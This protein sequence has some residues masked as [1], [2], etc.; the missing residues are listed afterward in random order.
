[1]IGSL[2]RCPLIVFLLAHWLEFVAATSLLVGLYGLRRMRTAEWAARVAKRKLLHVMAAD[3][4]NELARTS[5]LLTSAVRSGDWRRSGEFAAG[6]TVSLAEASGAW[7][8]LL[9]GFEEDKLDVATKAARALI[10]N[11]PMDEGT[12]KQENAQRM[13]E[14]CVFI[15]SIV[16]EIAGRL[17][18]AFQSEEE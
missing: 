16:G 5:N 6:L 12:I 13:V 2:D 1:V 18:Y 11:L 17:K 15:G 14:A 7:R 4:F 3:D 8:S 9:S 10:G